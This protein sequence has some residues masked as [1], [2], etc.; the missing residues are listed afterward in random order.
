MAVVAFGG[1]GGRHAASPRGVGKRGVTLSIRAGTRPMTADPTRPRRRFGWVARLAAGALLVLGAAAP[2]Q[3]TDVPDPDDL[4]QRFERVALRDDA[5]RPVSLVRW[6][7]PLNVRIVGGL[8]YRPAIAAHLATIR[9]LTSLPVQM[10]PEDDAR[11]ANL[12]V[13]FGPPEALIDAAERALWLTRGTQGVQHFT[14]FVIARGNLQGYS[15][16][17]YIRD[18]LAEAATH[19]CIAQEITQA[20]G[21]RGDMDD[22]RD[23]VF[24]SRGGAQALTGADRQIV[25]MLYDPRLRPGMS[26]ETAMPIVQDIAAE[27]LR[28][29]R[30]AQEPV[31]PAFSFAA[32]ADILRDDPDWR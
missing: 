27:I 32:A 10:V 15:A 29:T 25:R 9:D 7:W 28:P 21:P 30:Q 4:A 1:M 14:C 3:A 16:V 6:D 12:T 19:N 20:L 22:R 5:G 24:A 18:D 26:P 11:G 31:P 2:G 17:V 23:T 8:A 13:L